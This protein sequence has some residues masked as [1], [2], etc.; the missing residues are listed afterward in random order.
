MTAF[1]IF[2]SVNDSPVRVKW[3]YLS[4]E[5]TRFTGGAKQ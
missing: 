3:G 2:A 4:Q 5:A 1:D